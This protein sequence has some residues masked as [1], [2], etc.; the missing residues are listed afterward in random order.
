MDQRADSAASIGDQEMYMKY[1]GFPWSQ[2]V[3]APSF[4]KFRSLFTRCL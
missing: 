4:T 3:E 1:V 2:F